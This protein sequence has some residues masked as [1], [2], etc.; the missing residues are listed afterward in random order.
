MRVGFPSEGR[1]ATLVADSE[2]DLG[3]LGRALW[4]KKWRIIIPAIVVALATFVVVNMLTPRFAS[5]A[6]VLI[7]TRENV[8]LRPE[9]EKTSTD[10]AMPDEQAITSQVQVFRGRDLA[11]D[12]VAKLKLGERP[13]FDA[14]L[15]GLSPVT[16]ILAFFGLAKD[17]R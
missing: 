6:Q 4:R 15:K 14:L 5:D 9:A 16:R 2:F 12:V 10:R 11:R 13:E 7:D 17:P 3:A 8:F 1:D